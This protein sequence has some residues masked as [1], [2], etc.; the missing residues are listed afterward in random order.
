MELIIGITCTVGGFVLSYMTFQRRRDQEIASDTK[1]KTVVST[2]LDHI[3]EGVDNIKVEMR[4]NEKYMS[5]MNEQLIRVDES[6]KSAHKRLDK[7]EGVK[8]ND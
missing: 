7:L 3:S 8:L 2:K 5:R 4:A 6:A 1:E